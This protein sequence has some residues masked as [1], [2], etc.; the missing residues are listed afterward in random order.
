MNAVDLRAFAEAYAEQRRS[1]GRGSGGASE[2]LELPYLTAGPQRKQWETRARTFST[3]LDRI[4]RPM[5]E[6]RERALRV[7]DLG[8]GNGWLC[9]RL[10]SLG[11]ETTALD[12]RF[13]AVD[14][15]GAAD[16]YAQVLPQVFPRVAA[17]FSELPLRDDSFDV[18]VF[19]AALHYATDLPLV[20]SEA[21][22]VMMPGG[23]IAVLDSP[24]Y[25][26][27]RDGE[28]MVQ[29]KR[30][31][32]AQQFGE[33]AE[34]L[35][36]LPFIEYLT[37]ARLRA[38]LPELMWQRHHVRYPLWYELRPLGIRRGQRMPSRFDVWEARLP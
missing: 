30:A 26:H 33:R 23:R 17:T 38:A 22:R 11:H 1:E 21:A 14:G 20:L 10:A 19:N 18:V 9:Y 8:A 6:S 25:R 37:R 16:G 31:N 2:L 15:L 13:D 5:A 34:I 7:L 32:A 35:M 28:R 24:F 27:A 4:V 12:L 29:E 3:F 36:G